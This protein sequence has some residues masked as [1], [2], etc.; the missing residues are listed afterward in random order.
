[1]PGDQPGSRKI[2]AGDLPYKVNTRPRPASAKPFPWPHAQQPV[3]VQTHVMDT[4]K[5]WPVMI[6]SLW[7]VISVDPTACT[8]YTSRDPSEDLLYDLAAARMMITCLTAELQ[9]QMPWPEDRSEA[10]SRALNSMLTMEEAFAV[11][12]Q[13]ASEIHLGLHGRA[14]K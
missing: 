3:D 10:Y 6:G 13:C 11:V 1:M 12:M 4:V 14:Q 8:A 5:S 9:A 7:A 2:P